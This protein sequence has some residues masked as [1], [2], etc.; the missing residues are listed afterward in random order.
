MLQYLERFRRSKRGH[1]YTIFLTS[2]DNIKSTYLSFSLSPLGGSWKGASLIVLNVN[3]IILDVSIQRHCFLH[4][5]VLTRSMEAG[6]I[7]FFVRQAMWII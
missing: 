1:C 3:Q 7:C 6:S 2:L 4:T 5:I